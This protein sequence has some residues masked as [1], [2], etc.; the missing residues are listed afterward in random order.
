M[1]IFVDIFQR[2]DNICIGISSFQAGA[3]IFGMFPFQMCGF[4]VTVAERNGD[5]LCVIEIILLKMFPYGFSGC[6]YVI[7]EGADG[8][9]FQK[10]SSSSGTFGRCSA[11]TLN[12]FRVDQ[13]LIFPHHENEIAQSEAA[14]G[15]EFARYWMHNAF[16]KIDN[17]KMSKSLGN[18]FT[19]REIGEKYPL[20]VIR[21]FMLSAHYRSPLNFSDDLV[22]AARNGLERILTAVER[23][24]EAFKQAEDS[25][26]DD[27]QI[28]KVDE[29]VE[30]YE[31]AMD[32]DLNTAD[33]IAVIFELVR[34]SNTTIGE[35]ISKA[36]CEKILDT[37]NLL[38]G[39]LGIET[40]RE[41]ALLDEEIERLIE[42]RQQA[43]KDKDFARADAIRNEL[44]D[45][46]II[47]EDTREGVKWKKI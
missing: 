2:A 27:G 28:R 39:I 42:E 16:L 19:V 30:K 43:R 13:D 11:Q 9:Q 47:L 17:E 3:E 6:Q 7:D 33:A 4:I 22:E 8:R 46:G 23:A 32:D 45:K 5:L 31:A 14:N 44:Q 24:E 20:Q 36:Y 10:K 41:E 1:D 21:F 38:C 35:H 37:L 15:T 12:I 34:L 26:P 40:H 29:L 25:Q 18:F